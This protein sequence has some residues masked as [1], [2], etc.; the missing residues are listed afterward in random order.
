MYYVTVLRLLLIICGYYN[1]S[2][3]YSNYSSTGNRCIHCTSEQWVWLL[4]LVQYSNIIMLKYFPHSSI[5][6]GYYW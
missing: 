2:S 3:Y 5:Y 4:N 1:N 6:K